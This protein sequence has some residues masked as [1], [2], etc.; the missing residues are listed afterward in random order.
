MTFPILKQSFA[1][2]S[3]CRRAHL[4]RRTRRM[5]EAETRAELIDPALKAAGWGAVERQP[6][7]AR[8]AITKGRLG[9]RW[10]TRQ[11]PSSPITFC[12]IAARSSR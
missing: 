9:R 2:K 4:T 3:V 5:N 7:S 8:R 12:I 10:Q 11:S 1:A 6:H